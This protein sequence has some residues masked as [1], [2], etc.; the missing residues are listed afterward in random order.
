MPENCLCVIGARAN[1]QRLPGK[2]KRMLSGKPLYAITIEAALASGV[3]SRVLCSTDDAEIIAGLK[4]YPVQIHP[5]PDDLARGDVIFTE[6][7]GSILRHPQYGGNE[8]AVC[9]LT[10][11]HPFRGANHIR[12]AYTIFRQ[13][14]VASL[15]SLTRYPCP[16]SLAMT[17]QDGLIVNPPEGRIEKGTSGPA[18]Y[19]D[20][21][22][23]FVDRQRFLAAN[24]FYMRETAGY[25]LAWP[26]GLDIDEAED[27]ALAGRLAKCL[28]E[29]T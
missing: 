9:V 1:S 4:D 10:P 28:L 25:V 18:Y 13:R 21:A 12:E 6:V 8:A 7:L 15:A 3:F 19:P 14:R 20:G 16:P 11:C 5:R 27:L 24:R 2:N 26:Y 22:I 29:T 23:I 17:L